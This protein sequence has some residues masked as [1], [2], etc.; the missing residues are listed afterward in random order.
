M[1]PM[2]PSRPLL[3]AACAFATA[4]C[5]TFAPPPPSDV[6]LW[7]DAAGHIDSTAL[8]SAA[9]A[10]W[11]GYLAAH[12]ELASSLGDPRFHGDLRDVSPV[13]RQSRREDLWTIQRRVE[14]IAHTDLDPDDRLDRDLLL[15]SIVSESEMLERGWDEWDPG[16]LMDLL[17]ST[18]TLPNVQ[19]TATQR[20]RE[21]LLA[22]WARIPEAIRRNR[23][24]LLRAAGRGDVAARP[25]IERLI[26][27]CDAILAE[28]PMDHPLVEPALGGGRWVDLPPELPLAI[29]AERELGDASRQLELR[30]INRHVQRGDVRALGTRVLIPAPA[31][32]LAPQERGAFLEEVLRLVEEH[33]Q[34]AIANL[35]AT[36]VDDIFER[37]RDWQ[38]SGLVHLGGGRELFWSL[39]ARELGDG[40]ASNEDYASI[41]ADIDRLRG[42]VRV[43]ARTALGAND[44][45]QLRAA[46]REDTTAA[47]D[48]SVS[49]LAALEARAR[50]LRGQLPRAFGTIPVTGF[51]LHELWGPVS[52][53]M[54]SFV[55]VPGTTARPAAVFVDAAR[56]AQRSTHEVRA[57]AC[58]ELL[59]GRH[60]WVTS[61]LENSDLPRFRRHLTTESSSRGF[62]LYT[63][64]IGAELGLVTD[65]G[66]QLG[67]RLVLLEAACLAAMD[68]AI[69]H[70]GWGRTEALEFLRNHLPRAEADLAIAVDR[71]IARPGTAFSTW[72]TAR[73]LERLFTS[74]RTARGPAFDP[75]EYHGRLLAAGPVP[76][77]YL[78]RAVTR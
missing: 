41:V 65:P 23:E 57:L 27:V 19:P 73:T 46:L 64:M 58:V 33:I 39:V 1:V 51:E 29:L 4:A 74:E 70:D 53:E 63:L 7:P 67:A 76:A 47:L 69:H 25:A 9:E 42:E 78:V 35:R 28:A 24:A 6:G 13:A 50:E 37:S 14:R 56:L 72:L 21:Q 3:A 31:D 18:S 71:V 75:G 26:A 15:R 34:P 52:G 43:G 16:R 49:V 44:P 2:H 77:G 17:V 40:V 68:F 32:P 66:D 48:G 59:P 36:L 30:H 22:R 38:R 60:L 55:M 8:G 20:E 12:P 45:A 11:N 61:A 10:H 54:E 5:T 62:G